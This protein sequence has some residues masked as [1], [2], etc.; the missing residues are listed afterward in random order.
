MG[1]SSTS[2]GV[3]LGQSVNITCNVLRSIPTNYTI[4]WTLTR[5]SD[6]N[7]TTLTEDGETLIL[8]DITEDELGTYTCTT[9]NSADLSGSANITIGRKC[10]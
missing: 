7:V 6:G 9:T 3:I 1:V 8:T 2:T 4:V 5:I 10:N